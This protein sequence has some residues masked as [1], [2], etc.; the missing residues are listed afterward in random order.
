MARAQ[1]SPISHRK[2]A[3]PSAPLRLTTEDVGDDL[4]VVEA[5]R[6]WGTFLSRPDLPPEVV[7]ALSEP[8]DLE[9]FT[10]P[11]PAPGDRDV[12]MRWVGRVAL[13]PL[14]EDAV[15]VIGGVP[16]W[17]ALTLL[18]KPSEPPPPTASLRTSIE[19][20]EAT[21]EVLR[22]LFNDMDGASVLDDGSYKMPLTSALVGVG[23]LVEARRRAL[24]KI[25]SDRSV[26]QNRQGSPSERRPRGERG[27][28]A[29]PARI[30]RFL[31]ATAPLREVKRWDRTRLAEL[32]I[33]SG[34]WAHP[35]CP[36]YVADVLD[37]CGGN[38]QR[39]AERFASRL[40]TVAQRRR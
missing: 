5:H 4:E 25:F 31:S 27:Y 38:R 24:E 12:F 10:L 17:I 19:R 35:P 39:A 3:K 21:L 15:A 37:E 34:T 33:D 18:E 2:A 14:L 7:A 16:T 9:S 30:R 20:H 40:K 13:G 26:V 11:L 23:K 6:A 32:V 22:E 29:G 36:A 28:N 8:V 1:R